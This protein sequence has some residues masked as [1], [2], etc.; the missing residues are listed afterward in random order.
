MGMVAVIAESKSK[1]TNKGYLSH[2][3]TQERFFSR[4]RGRNYWKNLTLDSNNQ[5]FTLIVSKA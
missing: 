5:S 3:N 2:I 1:E 4:D